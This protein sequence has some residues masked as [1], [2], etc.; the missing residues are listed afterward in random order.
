MEDKIIYVKGHALKIYSDDYVRQNGKKCDEITIGYGGVGGQYV[1]LNTSDSN[2]YELPVSGLVYEE[3]SDGRIQYYTTCNSAG[4]PCTCDSAEYNDDG[5][6]HDAAFYN[7]DE[8]YGIS[9]VYD[10]NGNSSSEELFTPEFNEHTFFNSD[11]TRMSERYWDSINNIH[12]HVTY[13]NE[14]ISEAI[15]EYREDNWTKTKHFDIRENSIISMVSN[16]GKGSTFRWDI[17][18]VSEENGCTIIRFSKVIEH[19][20]LENYKRVWNKEGFLTCKHEL[21]DT[22]LI[23]GVYWDDNGVLKKEYFCV[24][25]MLIELIYDETENILDQTFYYKN[26]FYPGHVKINNT[27]KIISYIDDQGNKVINI[28]HSNHVTAF[29]ADIDENNINI[30]LNTLRP[31]E[32][33][34]SVADAPKDTRGFVEYLL[35]KTEKF[36]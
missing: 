25:E 3:Y 2:G 31:D 32:K 22:D 34:F 1:Y 35:E 10:Q 33:A 4:L 12:Y 29:S 13:N 9:V 19:I 20:K 26:K 28:K 11:G 8:D 36:W 30:I 15:Y 14:E 27:D 5:S 18:D 21:I 23:H 17:T 6:L 16:V 24:S 7:Y